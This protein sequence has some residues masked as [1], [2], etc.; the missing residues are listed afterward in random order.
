MFEGEWFICL[1]TGWHKLTLRGKGV[2]YLHTI[3]DA[4]VTLYEKYITEICER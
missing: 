3:G 1:T 2:M 4:L